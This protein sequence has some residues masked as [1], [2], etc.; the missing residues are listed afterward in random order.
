MAPKGEEVSALEIRS[1][2]FQSM[3][4]EEDVALGYVEKRQPGSCLQSTTVFIEK[5]GTHT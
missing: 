4:W 2:C 3:P 1:T 5:A